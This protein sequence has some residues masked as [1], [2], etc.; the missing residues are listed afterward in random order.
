LAALRQRSEQWVTFCQSRA[1]FLRQ[2]KGNPQTTQVLVGSSDF[3]RILGMKVSL[4]S[5]AGASEVSRRRQ[6]GFEPRLIPA[7]FW[8]GQVFGGPC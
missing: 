4:L 7:N 3:L 6:V 1:R 8:F 5:T 2:A